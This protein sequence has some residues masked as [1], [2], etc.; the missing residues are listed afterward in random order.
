MQTPANTNLVRVVDRTEA[1]IDADVM[2]YFRRQT[3]RVVRADAAEKP[4]RAAR[5]AKVITEQG[6]TKA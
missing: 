2:D 3:P 5:I 1:E 6:Q 4:T